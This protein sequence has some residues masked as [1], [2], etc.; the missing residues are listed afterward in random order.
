MN[1]PRQPGPCLL[2]TG[3]C[4]RYRAREGRELRRGAGA[5][6]VA[7]RIKRAALGNGRARESQSCELDETEPPGSHTV[8]VAFMDGADSTVVGMPTARFG[9]D[10]RRNREAC[11]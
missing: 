9:S 5:A 1:A 3:S 11:W 8:G 4:V 10:L 7:A 6:R 2:A